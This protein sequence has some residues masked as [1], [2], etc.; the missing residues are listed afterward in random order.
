MT[1]ADSKQIGGLVGGCRTAM[2]NC[3]TYSAATI[4]LNGAVQ[5]GLA[6]VGTSTAYVGLLIGSV[7]DGSNE[8]GSIDGNSGLCDANGEKTGE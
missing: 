5:T 1:E 4:T 8:L 6:N 2:T 7:M 3:Y